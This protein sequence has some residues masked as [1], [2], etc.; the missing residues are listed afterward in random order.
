M[1]QDIIALKDIKNILPNAFRS[2]HFDKTRT[3]GAGGIDKA[4]KM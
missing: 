1:C 2:V 3:S 4:A